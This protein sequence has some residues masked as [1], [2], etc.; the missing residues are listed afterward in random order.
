L[1]STITAKILSPKTKQEIY[2]HKPGHPFRNDYNDNSISG[3]KSL[4]EYSGY[5]KELERVL[6]KPEAR[7]TIHYY[8]VETGLLR[9]YHVSQKMKACYIEKEND[10][11][12]A[13]NIIESAKPPN[14]PSQ[15]TY[16][17]HFDTQNQ[18]LS[19][20]NKNKI[21]EKAEAW[22]RSLIERHNANDYIYLYRM[23][24]SYYLVPSN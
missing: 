19:Q 5:Q 21:R 9:K 1:K 4:K 2:A 8:L 10:K 20:D 7:D 16:E 17:E 3:P 23:G 11:E 22:A 18:L 24:G 15:S 13:W 14:I 12:A 6:S